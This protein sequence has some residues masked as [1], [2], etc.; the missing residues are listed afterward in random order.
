MKKLLLFLIG[1]S[2]FIISNAQSSVYKNFPDTNFIWVETSGGAPGGGCCCGGICINDYSYQL[3]F[4]GDTTFNNQVYSKYYTTGSMTAYI[5]GI[6]SCAPWCNNITSTT[7]YYSHDL[8]GFLRHDAAAKKVYEWNGGQELLM[9]DFTVQV[10]DSARGRIGNPTLNYI[11]AIDSIQVGNQFHK[12]FW[13]TTWN[14]HQ[15]GYDSAYAW[16][17]EGLGGS[18]GMEFEIY[19]VFERI[20]TIVCAYDNM[21]PVY[22]A[23]QPGCTIP[24]GKEELLPVALNFTLVPNPATGNVR[25]TG[26]ESGGTITITD[27]QGKIMY[28]GRCTGE[29]TDVKLQG[30][31]KGV[32]AVKLTNSAGQHAVKKLVIE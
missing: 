9:Y 1:T 20:G 16:I 26:G 32:Y 6:P 14:G 13:L 17:A 7:T 5:V 24:T 22:P 12:R 31:P 15:A 27:V 18:Q 23:N 8:G 21:V 11:S 19:P 25:I 3:F 29:T 30:I 2:C 4:D 10:G 28:S